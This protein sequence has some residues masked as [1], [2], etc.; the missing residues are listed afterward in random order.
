MPT[1]KSPLQETSAR[2]DDTD[3]QSLGNYLANI[4]GIKKLTLRQVEEASGQQVSNAYLSQLEKGRIAKPSPN[5]LDALSRVYTIPY[6]VLMEK[7]GYRTAEADTGV[8]RGASSSPRRKSALTNENLSAAEEAQLIEYLAF[9][10][11]R[12]QELKP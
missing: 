1:K 8:L 5:V 4:R 9:L 6:D 3:A 11:Q 12:K 10:R 7:A 2:R